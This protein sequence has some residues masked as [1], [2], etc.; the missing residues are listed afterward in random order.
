MTGHEPLL[1]MRRSGV[2][3]DCAWVMDD[4]APDNLV[5]ARSWHESPNEFTHK[6]QAHIHTKAADIP[7]AL[8]LRCLVGLQVHLICARGADRCK[9]LFD[10]I[11]AAKPALLIATHGDE[12]WTHTEQKNG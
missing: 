7:E 4:D 9:R 12:I 11:A 3:P 2:K 5:T 8:D 10:A 6:Y 1:Q